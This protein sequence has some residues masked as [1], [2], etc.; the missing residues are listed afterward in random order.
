MTDSIV[1]D[2]LYGINEKCDNMDK[3]LISLDS[4]VKELRI[5]PG[6]NDQT[7]QVLRSRYLN[8]IDSDMNIND[9]LNTV[10]NAI[11]NDLS[12]SNDLF[13]TTPTANSNNNNNAATIGNQRTKRSVTDKFSFYVTKFAP[14]TTS[15][16]ITDYLRD[17]GIADISSTKI[18]C[19]IP[20]GK[21]RSLLN[22]VS[23][24]I[25]TNEDIAQVITVPGFWPKKCFINE[26]VQK[27]VVDL[28]KDN[29]MTKQNFFRIP[30]HSTNQR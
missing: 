24:K 21:D 15:E 14:S 13:N 27:S 16:M 28:T 20:R 22:F 19:L 26:F 11:S 6:I 3:R 12:Y 18:S 25:D 9:Q 29:A 5:E 30:P 10:T 17:N 23:F 7:T 2:N 8:L 1:L 4:H